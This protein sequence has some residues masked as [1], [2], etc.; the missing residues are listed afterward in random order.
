LEEISVW[1][2]RTDRDDQHYGHTNKE[3]NSAPFIKKEFHGLVGVGS[4]VLYT[5]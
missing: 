1:C 2:D 3:G 4:C 5:I